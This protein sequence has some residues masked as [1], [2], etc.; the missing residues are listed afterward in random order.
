RL[1]RATILAA[2]V[3]VR[4][5]GRLI[6]RDQDAGTALTAPAARRRSRRTRPD[7]LTS[8]RHASV[9]PLH[10]RGQ[11]LR[12]PATVGFDDGRRRSGGGK[13]SLVKAGLL[14]RLA[15]HVQA[16]YVEATPDETEADCSRGCASAAPNCRSTSG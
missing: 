2:T 16:V 14:T 12:R 6:G 5:P 9:R 11:P 15:E 8:P 10:N 1:L 4:A 7:L 3:T 13:S